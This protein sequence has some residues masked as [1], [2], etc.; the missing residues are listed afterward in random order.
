MPVFVRRKCQVTRRSAAGLA[1]FA[2]F[3]AIASAP[4]AAQSFD[5][6]KARPPIETAICAS[7]R[8]GDLDQRLAA[9][10]GRATAA[11]ASDGAQ[12]QQLRTAQR[13]WVAARNRACGTL[14]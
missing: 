14:L 3:V 8:L 5:C 7:P 2:T 9:V 13:D 10:Y 6:S 1:G 4:A 12:V 11:L